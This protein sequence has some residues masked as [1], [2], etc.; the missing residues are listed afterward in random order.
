M[1]SDKS[2]TNIDFLKMTAHDLNNILTSI[3]NSVELLKIKISDSNQ[4]VL[5]KNIENNSLRAAEIVNDL[6]LTKEDKEKLKAQ[7]SVEQLMFDLKLTLEKSFADSL[8]IEINI[9][10]NIGDIFGN[11]SDLFR[12]LLNLCVNAKDAFADKILISACNTKLSKTKTALS[13][14]NKDYVLIEIADNGKGIEEENFIN[15]FKTGF[16]TK[17]SNKTSGLGLSIVKKV[18]DEHE[19]SIE[20]ESELRKGTAFKIYFPVF[21]KIDKSG[22]VSKNRK[23]LIAEDTKEI[24]DELSELLKSENYIPTA[25]YNGEDVLDF[26]SEKK[27]F[28]LFIIDKKMPGIDGIELIKLIRKKDLRVPIILATGSMPRG[29]ENSLRELNINKYIK[30]P[31]LFETLLK[32]IRELI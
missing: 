17:N 18:V 9:D 30:K 8:K 13:L 12:V 10:K 27:A 6:L 2:K 29:E 1:N 32:S 4:T 15:V 23:I 21:L 16:S 26:L 5:L 31:Y 3:L 7:V 11:Y 20:V 19:G 24:A 22:S 14:N 25:A 28:D